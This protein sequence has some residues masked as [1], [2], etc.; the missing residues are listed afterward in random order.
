MRVLRFIF[1]L[2]RAR[3]DH[4]EFEARYRNLVEQLPLITYIDS[5][6]RER[7]TAAYIS[8]QIEA[9]LGYPLDEWKNDPDAFP[10]HLHPEDRD[11]VLEAQAQARSTGEPLDL[12]Y[13]MIARDGR[14]VWLHDIYAVVRDEHGEPWYTQGFAVD[15][16]ERKRAEQDRERLLWQTSVQNAQLRRLDRTKD[17]F[18]ALVSHE[19]RTPL[20]SIRGYLELLREDAETLPEPY[21]DWVEVIDRNSSRLLSLVEDLLLTARAEEGDFHL[22]MAEFDLAALLAE[23][24]SAAAPTATSRLIELTHDVTRA[25][26]IRGDLRR[27]AQTFDNVL[28]NALKFTPTGGR[29]EV[30]AAQ[31]HGVVRIEVTDSGIGIPAEEQ[32]AVFMRFFR[33]ERAQNDAIVGAGLGLPIAKAI[34]DAH[35]G[36]ISFVSRENDG[37]TFTIEL[38]VQGPAD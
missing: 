23:Y 31:E 33:T 5:P 28:S 6:R 12:E 13:R 4:A 18:L 8:P 21:R 36:S 24:V 16:T 2:L 9:T 34:V 26:T 11:R 20:T 30:R 7:Q 19:L 35:G 17:E 15:V 29:V 37:T 38:P 3:R 1:S 27:V 32:D 14:T 10:K 25:G 22:D